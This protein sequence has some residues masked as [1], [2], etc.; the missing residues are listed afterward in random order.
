MKNLEKKK[1]LRCYWDAS[2]PGLDK[3]TQ[4]DVIASYGF[5]FTKEW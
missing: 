4:S 1:K 5:C 2:Q 3:E